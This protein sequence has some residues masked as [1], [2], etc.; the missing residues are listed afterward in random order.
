M[1]LW[2][3]IVSDD[4]TADGTAEALGRSLGQS[5]TM[6]FHFG[7]CLQSMIGQMMELLKHLTVDWDN[8]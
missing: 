7:L 1:T 8:R 2:A 5:M 4:G 3:L 6:I